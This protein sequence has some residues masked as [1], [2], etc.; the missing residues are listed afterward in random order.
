[1]VALNPAVRGAVAGG[2]HCAD[3]AVVEPRRALGRPAPD[4]STARGS[5]TF[6]A[7]RRVVAFDEQALVDA[8]GTRWEA[9]PRH[10]GHRRR[11]R[12]PSRHRARGVAAAP[13]PP[14]DDGDRALRRQRSPPRWPMPTPCGTTRPTT[15]S[16]A[17]RWERRAPVAAA[18]HL[19]LLMVQR[20]DGGLTIGDTHAYDEPFD[21]ALAEDPSDELLARAGDPAGHAAAAGDPALGRR[22]R[23]VRRRRRLRPGGAQRRRVDGD[24]A[25]WARHDVRPGA[26]PPTPSPRPECRRDRPLLAGLPRHGRH[27]RARRRRGRRGL[28][29]G[30]AIGRGRPATALASSRPG[31]TCATPWASPRP[32]SSPRCSIPS[33]RPPPPTEFARAYERIVAEGRVAPMPG[34]LEVSTRCG[35]GACRSASPPASRRPPGTR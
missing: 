31:S 29:R 18:H 14:P 34:A 28:H 15:S 17:I 23:P 4:P 27:H 19:Q 35:N 13:G 7:G 6:H 22:L 8:T 5:Y 32:M 24:R 2:L 12:S 20:A 9:R 26:S 30:P 25:R 11:L 10:R 3:D 16:I 33:R 1:M 21:F